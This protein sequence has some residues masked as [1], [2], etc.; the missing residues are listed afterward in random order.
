MSKELYLYTEIYD[1]IAQELLQSIDNAAD[2]DITLRISTP[3]GSVFAGWGIIAKL[4]EHKNKVSIKVD[5]AAMSMGTA[6]LV[7]FEDVECLDVSTFMLHRA[8]MF[9][10]NESERTLLDKVNKELRAKLE[11][12][13]DSEKLKELKGISIKDLFEAEKRIDLFLTAKEAKA[14][15]LVKKINKLA[16]NELQALQN[17]YFSIAAKHSPENNNNNNNPK[18]TMTIEKFKAEHPAV[19][20]EIVALGATQERERV[21]A[22]LV[23]NEV[24]PAAVKAAIESG[25]PVSAK[26]MAEFSLKALSNGTLNKIGKDSEKDTVETPEAEAKEKTAA[27]KKVSDFEAES[28]KAFNLK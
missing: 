19:Y 26:Q 9:V 4:L 6:V 16:P 22:L 28:R 10:E 14:V 2:D 3:G 15:G 20:A 18:I 1:F 25:K 13:I 23:Y 8:D 11:A 7:F 12:K 21:E 24:D 5:G 27:E 17:K